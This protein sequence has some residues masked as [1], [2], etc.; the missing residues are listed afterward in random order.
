MQDPRIVKVEHGEPL[1]RE[2][3]WHNG[4]VTLFTAPGGVFIRVRGEHNVGDPAPQPAWYQIE[5]RR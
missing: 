4:Q 2:T 1:I 5:L 3:I